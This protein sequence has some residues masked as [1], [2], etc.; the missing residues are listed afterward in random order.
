MTAIVTPVTQ[1][2]VWVAYKSN[3]VSVRVDK[4]DTVY[5]CLKAARKKQPSI[6]PF[7][8]FFHTPNIQ[9]KKVKWSDVPGDRK[10][11]FLR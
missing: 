10:N 4:D 11:I 6:I 5:D 7:F 2:T 9:E 3:W 1:K 8:W